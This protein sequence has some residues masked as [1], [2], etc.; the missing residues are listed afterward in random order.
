MPLQII[1]PSQCHRFVFQRKHCSA[2]MQ[3]SRAFY[4]LCIIRLQFSSLSY[5]NGLQ[6]LKS[7]LAAASMAKLDRL[8]WP[9]LLSRIC[10]MS[11]ESRQMQ[12]S[13][14]P[15]QWKYLLFIGSSELGIIHPGGSRGWEFNEP[16]LTQEFYWFLHGSWDWN[17][18]TLPN[19]RLEIS[20]KMSKLFAILKIWHI[21]SLRGVLT[22]DH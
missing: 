2:S 6:W 22:N 14:D 20:D 16:R 5:N 7:H 15:F 4:P 8:I 12:E 1:W 9:W 21:P 10:W 19:H 13:F 17:S 3:M 11:E 18:K